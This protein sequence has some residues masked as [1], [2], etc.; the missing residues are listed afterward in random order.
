V[1]ETRPLYRAAI[2]VP[3]GTPAKSALDDLAQAMGGSWAFAGGELYLKAGVYTAPV[4]ALTEADLAVVQRDGA[5][6]T[7]VPIKISVHKARAQKINTIKA[8]IWDQAQDYKQV[9]L[10]PVVGA[11]L[12]TRDGVE[13]SQEIDFPAIGYAPQAQHVAGVLMRDARDPLVVELPFKLRAYP[14]ELFD[15]VSL[16]LARYGWSGKT[17]M[18]L[19]RTWGANGSLVLTLKETNAAI[20]QVDAS[21]Q[22]G[23]FGPN[24]NL[25]QPWLVA[26]VGPLTATSGASVATVQTDGTV[27]PRLKV[28]WPQIADAAVKQDGKIEVQYREHTSAGEWTTL[29]AGGADTQIITADVKDGVTYIVRARGKTSSA[30]GN[31]CVQVLVTISGTAAAPTAPTA[32]ATGGLFCVNLAWTFGGAEA[33]VLGTEIWWAAV[34]DRATAARLTFEPYPSQKYTHVGL[35]PGQGGY[36]WLRVVNTTGVQSTWYPASA[37]AGLHATASR[38]P[39]DLLEQLQNALTMP[40]LAAELAGPIALIPASDYASGVAMLG[41]ALTSYDLGQRMV[42][43]EAVTNATITVDPVTGR[44]LLLATAVTTT[45]VEARLTQ[46]EITLDAASGAITLQTGR[47]SSVEDGLATAQGQITTMAGQISLSA[48]EVYVDSAVS[49]IVGVNAAMGN[50]ALQLAHTAIQNALD[51]FTQGTTLRETVANVAVARQTIQAHASALEANATWQTAMAAT[52]A[53]NGSAILTEQNVRATADNAEAASRSLLEARVGTAEGAISANSAAIS[54]EAI[55]R[56]DAISAEAASRTTL[57]ARVTTTEADIG[58]LAGATNEN[59][60]AIINEAYV[61][62]TADIAEAYQREQLQARL[63]TGDFAAVKT[64]SSATANKVG[65]IEAKWSVQVQ[66]MADGHTAMAGIALVAGAGSESAV[67]VLADKFLIYRPDGTGTPKPV[68]VMGTVNGVSALGFD[69]NLVIDGSLAARAIRANTVTADQLAIG[70][71]AATACVSAQSS[72]GSAGCTMTLAYAAEVQ[73]IGQAA[74]PTELYIGVYYRQNGSATWL[75]AGQG[76]EFVQGTGVVC[77]KLSMSPGTWD[78]GVISGG[79]RATVI[80]MASIR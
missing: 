59:A 69:G 13:L 49:G 66:T 55:A 45:D 61:R 65:L 11:A 58:A 16:T 47:L 6:E 29:L 44:I 63:D 36:Y 68:L 25:P 38:D 79:I 24:T 74:L 12:R 28:A 9:S 20:T 33:D 37:T 48:S 60:A 67:L 14:I 2:V 35:A 71:N 75:H 77:A 51:A 72:S 78:F 80:A 18:V 34:N 22:P 62:A 30:I 23:G 41:E 76:D 8:K 15:T 21:F 17:F 31:W 70:G 4:M 40:Q 19:G 26:A 27:V 7:Q 64:Q 10:P 5:S 3:Y 39:S 43:Q 42:F 54:T 46:V 56:A 73:I 32:T 1:T 53:Q 52:V 50:Q 57:A